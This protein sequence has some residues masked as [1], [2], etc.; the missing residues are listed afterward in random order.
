MYQLP[1]QYTDTTWAKSTYLPQFFAD[2]LGFLCHV[3]STVDAKILEKHT[4]SILKAEVVVLG[5]GGTYIVADPSAFLL[6][7]YKNPSTSW[8]CHFSPE[9]GKNECQNP[10]EHCHPHCCENQSFFL[11]FLISILWSEYNIIKCN[12]VFA[13]FNSIYTRVYTEPIATAM[14]NNNNQW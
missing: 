7:C 9:N 5:S 10:E 4:V 14:S 3:D 1:F 13:G 2:V 12:I 8:H 6:Q 11:L